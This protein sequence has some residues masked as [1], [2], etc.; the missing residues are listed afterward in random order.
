MSEIKLLAWERKSTRASPLIYMS[1]LASDADGGDIQVQVLPRIWWEEDPG[2]LEY[3]SA[4]ERESIRQNGNVL[5]IFRFECVDT[6]CMCMF[7][8]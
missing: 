5:A 2:F 7:Y 4:N 1:M 6:R 3:T 8:D